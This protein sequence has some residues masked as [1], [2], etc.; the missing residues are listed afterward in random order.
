MKVGIIA[1]IV[2]HAVAL[3]LAPSGSTKPVESAAASCRCDYE[4]TVTDTK[5]PRALTLGEVPAH[6]FDR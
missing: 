5:A 2:I 1:S 6:R 3:A 4:L